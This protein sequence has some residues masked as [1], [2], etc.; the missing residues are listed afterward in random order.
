MIL[1]IAITSSLKD[2]TMEKKDYNYLALRGA[3]TTDMEFVEEFNLDPK[4][5]N[6]PAINDA[7]LDVIHK[8]NFETYL[9]IGQDEKEAKRRA[10]EQRNVARANIKKLI[11]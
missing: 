11:R 1:T 3:A 7:M 8:K 2:Y 5:A 9:R 10:D 6:T 4:L